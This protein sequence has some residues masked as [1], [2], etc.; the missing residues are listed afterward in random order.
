MSKKRKSLKRNIE[1]PLWFKDVNGPLD[2]KNSTDLKVIGAVNAP[3]KQDEKRTVQ[4]KE[5]V[6]GSEY[7]KLLRRFCNQIL[8]GVMTEA[9]HKKNVLEFRL[10]PTILPNYAATQRC[11]NNRK[12][13]ASEALLTGKELLDEVVEILYLDLSLID[14]HRTV[15]SVKHVNR[16]LSDD[17]MEVEDE[18]SDDEGDSCKKSG[19]KRFWLQRI[20]PHLCLEELDDESADKKDV[21]DAHKFWDLNVASVYGLFFESSIDLGV[22][23]GFVV[24][25]TPAAKK[26][27]PSRRK[28]RL[29]ILKQ[30]RG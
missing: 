27:K 11:N 29:D 3:P 2:K 18:E 1:S 17:A 4:G 15:K 25:H 28:A 16:Q 13:S 19:H 12:T 23:A 26:D 5:V 14:I 24:E 30:L 6:K 8:L 9:E 10:H 21:I 22:E 20:K 7:Y